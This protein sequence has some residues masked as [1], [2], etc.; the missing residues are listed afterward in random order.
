MGCHTKIK[1]QFHG[2]KL[3]GLL[4]ISYGSNQ[5]GKQMITELQYLYEG[6]MSSLV[7]H[8]SPIVLHLFAPVGTVWNPGVLILKG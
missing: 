8:K 6:R 7:Y 4:G 3:V 5:Y 1:L 2:T